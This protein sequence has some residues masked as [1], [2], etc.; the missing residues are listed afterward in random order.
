LWLYPTIRGRVPEGVVTGSFGDANFV[1]HGFVRADNGV[2]T[3]FDDPTAG[4]GFFQGTTPVALN[5]QGAIVGCYTD[6]NNATFGF[7]RTSGGI[8]STLNPPGGSHSTPEVI[9]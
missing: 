3:T 4:T 9:S 7:L 2:I 6:T 5:P 1:L 8:F